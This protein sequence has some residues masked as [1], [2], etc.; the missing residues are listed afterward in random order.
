MRT[1]QFYWKNGSQSVGSG[2]DWVD[3]FK[4]AGHQTKLGLDFVD[5]VRSVTV[6]KLSLDKINNFFSGL[7]CNPEIELPEEVARKS[8]LFKKKIAITVV[9]EQDS[10]T[11]FAELDCKI[12]K[13]KETGEIIGVYPIYIIRKEKIIDWWK[14]NNYATEIK[15]K[16]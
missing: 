2:C 9:V 14:K 1:F 3:A 15:E 10:L 12:E 6:P 5:F 8:G 7:Y 13:N 16:I 11:K 4:N